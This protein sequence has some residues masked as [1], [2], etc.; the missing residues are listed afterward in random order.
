MFYRRII[1]PLLF[2]LS[3]AAFGQETEYNL[4]P[5]Y[6]HNPKKTVVDLS[7]KLDTAY[8]GKEHSY[9]D[10]FLRV[11]KDIPD[12]ELGKTSPEY[13][14]YVKEGKKYINSLSPAVRSTFT[15]TELWY[16]YAYDPV[17]KKKLKKI[18]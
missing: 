16:I 5:G 9:S 12:S 11:L 14:K 8:T 3:T 15:E 4:P 13:Q 17:L 1:L 7:Y 6:F 10:D 18:K 2:I